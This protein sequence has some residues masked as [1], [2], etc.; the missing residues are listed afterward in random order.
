MP[1]SSATASASAVTSRTTSRYVASTTVTSIDFVLVLI[2]RS[3]VVLDFDLV[4][5]P[6]LIEPCLHRCG[7]IRY[8]ISSLQLALRIFCFS[9]S[10]RLPPISSI[11]LPGTRRWILVFVSLFI[12][13]LFLLFCI[14][15]CIVFEAPSFLAQRKQMARLLPV[16]P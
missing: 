11:V 9:C 10:F 15:F 3:A 4:Q 5:D 14:V 6:F 2:V 13:S 12:V 7:K 8:S 1:C 16:F